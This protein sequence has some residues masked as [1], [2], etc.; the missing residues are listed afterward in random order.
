MTDNRKSQELLTR[1]AAAL[2][3]LAPQP[4]AEADFHA[5]DAFVWRAESDSLEQIS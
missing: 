3:R 5:A 2:E 4:A 1:I